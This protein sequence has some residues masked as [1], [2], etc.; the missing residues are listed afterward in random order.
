MAHCNHTLITFLLHMRMCMHCGCAI[1]P[2]TYTWQC[3]VTH[4]ITMLNRC[5]R[6]PH[7]LSD[8]LP[9]QPSTCAGAV[10]HTYTSFT[11]ELSRR[12]RHA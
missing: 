2:R 7:V 11:F 12:L 5:C 10:I 1:V 3:T 4:V 9:T 8:D 6:L